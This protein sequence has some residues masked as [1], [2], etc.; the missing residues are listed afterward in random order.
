[1]ALSEHFQYKIQICTYTSSICTLSRKRVFSLVFYVQLLLW[2][3]G[4]LLFLCMKELHSKNTTDILVIITL[5][6]LTTQ[7]YYSR[8]DKTSWSQIQYVGPI[9]AQLSQQ[10]PT[11]PFGDI[12]Q[13]A[14]C[15]TS[16]AWRSWVH[17]CF[18]GVGR[19]RRGTY[20]YTLVEV[21]EVATVKR[22]AVWSYVYRVDSYAINPSAFYL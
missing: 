18:S 4:H 7:K 8:I 20:E 22:L 2:Y 1:M 14:K 21:A 15:R 16:P 12:V 11:S 10:Y 3:L 19:G 17:T 5:F 9:L 13:W 6:N